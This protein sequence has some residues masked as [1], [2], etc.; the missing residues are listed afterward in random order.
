M[1]KKTK[2]ATKIAGGFGLLIIISSILGY[3]GVREINKAEQSANLSDM[4][5]NAMKSVLKC[6]SARGEFL[7]KGNVEDSKTEKTTSDIWAETTVI[8][9]KAVDD[10]KKAKGV[11]KKTNENLEQTLKDFDDYDVLRTE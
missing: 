3:S 1:K 11:D 9:R 6:G 2:L 5:G 10:L 4:S 8:M 7:I